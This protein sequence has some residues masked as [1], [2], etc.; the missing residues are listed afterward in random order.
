MYRAKTKWILAKFKHVNE[1]HCLRQFDP[2]SCC[3]TRI[4][5]VNV[6][7]GFKGLGF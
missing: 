2:M 7:L 6:V 5:I 1:V 3:L 4:V